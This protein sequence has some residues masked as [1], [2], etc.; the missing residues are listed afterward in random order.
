MIKK[1]TNWRN[2]CFTFFVRKKSLIKKMMKKKCWKIIKNLILTK[3]KMGRNTHTQNVTKLQNSNCNKT[4]KL[5]LW[6]IPTTKIVTKLKNLF[7][8]N[9]IWEN[10]KTQ[11]VRKIKM[12]HIKNS[13]CNITQNLKMWQNKKSQIL[14][15]L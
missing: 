2:I 8:T 9:K 3:L 10:S 5:K 4:Q 15:K 1:K 7:V 11:N 14:T 12:S 13:N 6:Q